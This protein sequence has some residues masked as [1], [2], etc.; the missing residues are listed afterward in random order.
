[1]HV[2][3]TCEQDSHT[4]GNGGQMD[5]LPW[6][7]RVHQSPNPPHPRLP[8]LPAIIVDHFSHIIYSLPYHCLARNMEAI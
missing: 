7:H 4:G 5:G 1:M 2:N 3:L 8:H 6:E